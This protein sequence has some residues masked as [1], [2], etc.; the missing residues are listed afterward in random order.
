MQCIQTGGDNPFIQINARS[1]N[2]S[3]LENCGLCGSRSG[4]LLKRDGTVISMTEAQQFANCYLVEPRDQI[5][6]PQRKECGKFSF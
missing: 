4:Q 3:L 5:L 6:R 2:D 1:P